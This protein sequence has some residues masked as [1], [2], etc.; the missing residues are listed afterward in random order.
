MKNIIL[1]LPLFILTWSACSKSEKHAID[2][3]EMVFIPAGDFEMGCAFSEVNCGSLHEVFLD[4]YYIGKYEVTQ[5]RWEAVMGYNPSPYIDC[6]GDCPV[7]KV[8]WY[9]ILVFCNR[10][11]LQEGFDP[12]YN[13]NS[14]TNPQEWGEIPP[15]LDY[16]ETW[17]AVIPDFN[18]NGYRLPTEAEWEYAARGGPKSKG[19][20]YVGTDN[21]AD[22]FCFA[23]FCDLNCSSELKEISQNDGHQGIA[24][25]GSYRPNE[26]GLHDMGGNLLERCW[27]WYDKDYYDHSP[28]LNPTGPNSASARIIRGGSFVLPPSYLLVTGRGGRRPSVRGHDVGFR[29]CRTP[30]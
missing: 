5:S 4:A 27:D 22:L 8:S 13:I 14:S 9:S 29:L 28:S 20:R 7:S 1:M 6:G 2:A 26:L 30:N 15:S 18:A 3:E 10:L 19:F 16:N 11:S 17:N 23:N 21:K 25:I 24:P 12:V